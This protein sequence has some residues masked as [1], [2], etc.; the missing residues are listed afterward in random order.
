M[1]EMKLRGY[2]LPEDFTGSDSEKLQQAV[3]TAI[4]KDI[5]K[6]ILKGEYTL[7][8]TV[9]LGEQIHILFEG[10]KLTAAGDFPVFVNSNLCADEFYHSYS[11]QQDM[12]HINGEGEIKGDLF[13]YNA[14]RI[15]VD[16]LKIEGD[17]KFEFSNEIRLEHLDITG[18]KAIQ[19]LRGTNNVIAQYL[20]IKAADTAFLFDTAKTES[21]YVIGKDAEVH[22]NI[23]KDCEID[24]PVAF[25]ME[26]TENDRIF[27]TVIE[28][29]KV[30]GKGLV[31]SAKRGELAGEQYRDITAQG[32]TGAAAAIELHSPVKHCY[33]QK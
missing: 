28:D 5:R 14:Y 11:F 10:A 12:F 24:A 21:D 32:I 27:N 15:V 31:I 25:A 22:E 3:D 19:L 29:H 30:T 16:G 13:F 17:L 23:I 4:A 6:V 9:F 8:K 20:K 2:V 26:A 33:L 1:D 18:K 7:E